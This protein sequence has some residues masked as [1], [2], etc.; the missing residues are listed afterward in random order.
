[1]TFLSVFF[2]QA[3]NGE[4]KEPLQQLVRQFAATDGL[5]T[6]FVVTRTRREA[7]YSTW[8][9]LFRSGAVPRPVVALLPEE[10]AASA[11]QG[12]PREDL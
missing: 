12:L 9:S 1:M 3:L 7:L 2:A 6:C 10:A 4:D 11:Y 5:G 8:E